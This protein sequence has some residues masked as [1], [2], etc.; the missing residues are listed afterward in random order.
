MAES[1]KDKI[2]IVGMGCSKFGERWNCG[3]EDLVIEA[4]YEAYED[5]GVGPK[6]IQAGW[7]GCMFNSTAAATLAFPLKFGTIP[8]TRVENACGSGHEAIKGACYA[9]AAKAF[10]L[11]IAVGVEK[12]KDQGGGALGGGGT[13]AAGTELWNPVYF[14][15]VGGPSRYALAATRYFAKYGLNPDEGKRMLAKISVK[16]HYYGARNPKAHLRREVTE[17]QVMN[18]PIISWPLGLFDCCG[19]SDGA[20]AAILCRAE[21]AKK[22][23]DDYVVFKALGAAA[24]PGTG[25]LLTTYDYTWWDETEAAARQAYEQAG[26]KEP[27]KEID[28]VELHDCFSIAE[29]VATESLFLCGRGKYKEE[30]SDTK[31][32]YIE[33]DM[34]VNTS[35]GLKS[36]GHPIGAS[37]CR[38]VYES[39]KQIQGKAKEPSRQKKT[40]KTDKKLSLAHNQGGHPGKFACNITIIG[41]P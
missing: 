36:F 21:D 18:A 7:V 24:G 6:D 37:G 5:A 28:L 14:Y 34:S 9:L 27:R 20:A 31:A 4:A 33:G 11:V 22:Y 17:E 13:A 23:R 29:L 32:Y 35:G 25:K 10:D 12:L 8:C 3:L 40:W 41:L 39:Y 1:I 26:R 16:S 15:G 2:A 38:E 30:M 19:N